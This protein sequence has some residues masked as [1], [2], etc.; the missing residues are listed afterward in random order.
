MCRIPFEKIEDGKLVNGH[1]SGFF[2]EIDNFPIKYAL[3]TNNHILNESNI[4]I[5]ETINFNY[6]EK[7]FFN[8][9]VFST[10]SFESDKD[11]DF[12]YLNLIA[13]PIS[14]FDSFNI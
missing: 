10:T 9:I 4:E 14:K 2:C 1:G 7:S 3:F 8:L 6:L 13:L 12:K 5:G 11:L